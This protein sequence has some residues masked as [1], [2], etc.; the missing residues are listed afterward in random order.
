[1]YNTYYK[2]VNDKERHESMRLIAESCIDN[3]DGGYIIL[4]TLKNQAI[5]RYNKIGFYNDIEDLSQQYEN[6]RDISIIVY[7]GYPVIAVIKGVN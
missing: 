5:Q 4:N 1:M 6:D 7:K 3:R 2:V